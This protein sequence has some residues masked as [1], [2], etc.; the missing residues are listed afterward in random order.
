MTGRPGSNQCWKHRPARERRRR[1]VGGA[2]TSLPSKAW[3]PDVRAIQFKLFPAV[4]TKFQTNRFKI[5]LTAGSGA[6]QQGR[7]KSK[8]ACLTNADTASQRVTGQD[9]SELV[10]YVTTHA[11]LWASAGRHDRV[12][13]VR[14]CGQPTTRLWPRRCC[15]NAH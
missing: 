8:L 3:I 14:Q 9:E 2:A 1:V 15:T 5:K 13:L 10:I 6:V 11:I 4:S 7:V 12:P